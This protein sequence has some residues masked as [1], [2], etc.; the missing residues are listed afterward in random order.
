GQ[1]G[2]PGDGLVAVTPRRRAGAEGALAQRAA[3]R[4]RR[5]TLRVDARNR[6][7]AV[8]RRGDDEV[9]GRLIVDVVGRHV[10]GD[11]QARV[12]A[13]AVGAEEPVHL[14]LEA[15]WEPTGAFA[16]QE[17][18]LGRMG[19]ADRPRRDFRLGAFVMAFD[20][21]IL[22]LRRHVDREPEL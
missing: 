6:E 20:A 21:E 7:K 17:R 5:R 2:R 4:G 8:P 14:G 3:L 15:R 22:L 13:G 10:T 16:E 11:A 9:T 1:V 19:T 12:P 18:S